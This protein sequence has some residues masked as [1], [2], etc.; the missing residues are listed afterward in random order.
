MLIDQMSGIYLQLVGFVSFI[1]FDNIKQYEDYLVCLKVV[2]VGFDQVIGVVRQ[3]L[4][5]GMML[6]KYL[7]EVVVKQID[8]IGML[9]G[10]D[11]VFVELLKYFLVLVLV[12]DQVWLKM[13]ILVVIDQDVCL[14]YGKFKNF[15]VIDYVLY[16]CVQFGVWDL[17]NGEV[18]Y[19]FDVKQMIIIDK[20]LVEIYQ[21][22]LDEVVCIEGEMI[23]IVKV[24]GFKDLVSFC[25]LLKSNLKIYVI[26]CE[27]IFNCYCGFLVQMQLELFKLFGLLFKIEVVVKLVEVFCEK[28]VVVVEYYQGMLDGLWLGQ[29]FVNIGDFVNCSVLIIELIVYYEG[30][31]GYYMQILIVQMLFKLLLFCQQGG[32][33][34]YVEGWVLY[35]EQLGKDIGFYKDLLFDYGCFSD[36]LLCVDCFVL[37]I[38]VYYKYWMC[39]Q[40]VDFFYVYFSEDELD[41]QVEIDCYIIWLGQVFV[42]KMGEL[43]ILVLCIKVKQEFGDRFDI[44]V[45]YDV[46]FDGGVLLLDVLE[47]CIDKWIVMQKVKV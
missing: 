7:L 35:V 44:C 31:F 21:F 9:V 29:I 32:Y 33:I 39:Q 34:V 23:K 13:V 19:C 47:M 2:L 14:V 20:I 45:F 3:G 24:Q 46:V 22:G 36:E 25:V 27:D 5:D 43:K 6:L 16:G 40:M 28:E 4:C 11:S 42:Y 1:L 8:V 38:G 18:I 17:F 26:L 10:M 15:V 30:I 41:V 37:D 12:V